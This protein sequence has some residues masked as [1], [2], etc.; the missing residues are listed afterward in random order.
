[1]TTPAATSWVCA[2][3]WLG[4]ESVARDVVIT[5]EDGII[6]AVEPQ[7]TAPE[8]ATRLE[9]LVLPGF[10]N[11]HSHAFHRALRGRTERAVGSFWSWRE[12]MYELAGRLSPDNYR[13]LATAAFAEM[14]CAGFTT[15]GEFHYLHHDTDGTEY[16]DAN[17]MSVAL[18]DAARAAGIR[19][20]LLDACYLEAAPG[21]P[22]HGVQRRFCDASVER[23]AS[24]VDDLAVAPEHAR[25]G[26]AVHSVRAVPPEAIEVVAGW[27]EAHGAVLHAHVSE[28][29]RENDECLAAYGSTPTGLLARAGALSRRFTAVHATHLVGEDRWHL[30][31]AGATACVCPTTERNLA[32]GLCELTELAGAGVALCVGTDCH[33]TI[34]PFEELRCLEGHERLRTTTRGA[35]TP[36]LLLEAG[37][38]PGHR[39]LG[40]PGVGRLEVGAAC[41]LVCVATTSVRLA[42]ADVEDLLAAAVA[43]ATAADVSTVVI[44]GRLV[45]SG[46][47]HAS[48]D[49]P[50]ALERAVHAVWT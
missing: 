26:A 6:T 37:T 27:A 13:D 43:G 38:A 41:D 19:I 10:A 22:P 42:G 47:Q 35:L 50:T 33:A 30:G 39:A 1:V 23:W 5:A 11:V 7:G 31:D 45:A 28:Q 46:G 20:T 32:D 17:E 4:G 44:G 48:I 8:G 21:H 2:W 49:V 3:A 34:D 36:S 24:R 15:V 29:P 16:A 9:G 14:V 25:A 12:A 18:L 40:W